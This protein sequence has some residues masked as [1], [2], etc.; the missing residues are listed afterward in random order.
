MS[1]QTKPLDLG[2]GL[3]LICAQMDDA[4]PLGE[5]A[6]PAIPSVPLHPTS[7]TTGTPKI[8]I[9]HGEAAA[10]EARHYEQTMGITPEDTLLC[11]VPMSHAYG[12][13]TCVTMPLTSGA[14]VVSSRRFQPHSSSLA[15][16]A[17][18]STASR[19]F[20]RFRPCFTCS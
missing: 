2:D 4:G 17:K 7:G 6:F 11:V 9:R 18:S 20:L 3:R 5:E 8:A 1:R 13:G 15:A 12:F 19:R 10:A 16:L 14:S